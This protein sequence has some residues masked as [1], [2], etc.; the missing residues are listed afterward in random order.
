MKSVCAA[1]HL[2]RAI[3]GAYPLGSNA[4]ITKA[5][6]DG[7][8]LSTEPVLVNAQRELIDRWGH[9]FRFVVNDHGFCVIS[10]GRDELFNTF[11]LLVY[12]DWSR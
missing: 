5:L 11:D 7:N 9:P 12:A 6:I 10:S 8:C 3:H 2:Y 1:A 4:Q